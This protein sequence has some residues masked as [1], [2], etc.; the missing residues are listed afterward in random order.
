VREIGIA[1]IDEYWEKAKLTENWANLKAHFERDGFAE[2]KIYE[3]KSANGHVL[4]EVVKFRHRLVP[5][6][7]KFIPRYASSDG[8]RV[9]VG[10]VRLP[11]RLPELI[12]GKG[13]GEPIV[14]CE[15]EKDAD[16][17]IAAGLRATTVQGSKWTDECA[18]F[19]E[20]ED[21]I[22]V[23]DN[24]D[25]GRE[26][27][28]KTRR[29]CSGSPSGSSR[30][31]CPGTSTS[32]TRPSGRARPSPRASGSYRTSSRSTRSASSTATAASERASS[33]S[34]SPP[35]WPPRSSGSART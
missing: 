15:G 12:A 27:A 30:S 3:Y 13:S 24:D 35:R 33:C 5:T 26:N 1:D 23:P 28:K 4:Y 17:A 29:S 10:P 9:G 20:G 19:L 11:Y 18:Q 34:C 22:V 31:W 25:K 14:Y 16:A 2:E 8:M 7:R 21:V 6:K 32:S